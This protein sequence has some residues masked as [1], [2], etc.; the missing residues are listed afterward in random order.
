MKSPAAYVVL[1]VS[2][3]LLLAV[4][5]GHGKPIDDNDLD[6]E[7]SDELFPHYKDT[8]EILTEMYNDDDYVP[9]KSEEA[10]PA[11]ITTQVTQPPVFNP[12]PEEP[13]YFPRTDIQLGP[14][15]EQVHKARRNEIQGPVDLPVPYFVWKKD[16]TGRENQLNYWK[17]FYNSMYKVD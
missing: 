17:R 9:E 8:E 3:V 6:D 7:Y 16:P 4:S 14:L 1:G 12:V 13:V 2:S 10:H 15:F 11:K 5:F